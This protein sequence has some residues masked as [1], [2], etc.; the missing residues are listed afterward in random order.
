MPGRRCRL[1]SLWEMV[2][3]ISETTQSPVYGGLR[4]AF[5][6]SLVPGPRRPLWTRVSGAHRQ[7]GGLGETARC[8]AARIQIPRPV[9]QAKPGSLS[10][11]AASGSLQEPPW[12]QRRARGWR[13]GPWRCDGGRLATAAGPERPP[14]RPLPG[15]LRCPGNL[16]PALLTP[17]V[18]D[19]FL[20]RASGSGSFPK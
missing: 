2:G 1:L 8:S 19:D 15:G 14:A 17:A 11:G 9:A 5:W 10:R 4:L 6:I 3:D 7:E 12:R 16:R 20:P 18:Q 13:S